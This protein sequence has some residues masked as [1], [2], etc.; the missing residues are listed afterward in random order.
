MPIFKQRNRLTIFAEILKTTSESVESITK[1]DIVKSVN[2]SY[3][4]A[5]KFLSILLTEELLCLDMENKYELTKK[6]LEFVKN[7]K[8]MNLE[9]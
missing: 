6:G 9:V 4:Q 2:L 7:I 3:A 1:T 8:S 5:D